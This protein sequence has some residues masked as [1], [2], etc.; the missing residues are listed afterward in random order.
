MCGGRGTRLDAGVEKPLFDVGGRPMVDR[1]R[2]A[3]DASRVDTTYAVVSP[4]AP[5]TRDHVAAD[6]PVV[7]TPG[8]GYVADLSSALERVETPVLT[9]AADLPLLEGDVVDAVLDHADGS[10][11]VRVPRA[12][13]EALGASCNGDAAWVPTGLN[14]VGDDE[15]S[16]YRSYDARLAVNVNRRADAEL[17]ERLLAAWEVSDGP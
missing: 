16:V 6:L 2:D 10:T 1:V 17:A 4:H 12:L 7:E 14:V 5:A 11:S 9:V 13:K 15:D 8:E 3:L